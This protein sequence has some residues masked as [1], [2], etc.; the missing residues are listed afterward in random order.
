V[1]RLAEIEAAL[2]DIAAAY[3]DEDWEAMSAV[4]AFAAAPLD[5]H[6]DPREA[7]RLLAKVKA[8][9]AVLKAEADQVQHEL[10]D[11]AKHLRA[12]RAYLTV[13]GL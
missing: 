12:A 4:P 13:D 2:R 11:Q 5:D 6:A 1:N 8:L 9:L 7:E 10:D 3:D